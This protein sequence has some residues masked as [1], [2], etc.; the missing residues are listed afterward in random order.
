MPVTRIE[1]S[2]MW[3]PFA[4]V[5]ESDGNGGMVSGN[6]AEANNGEPWIHDRHMCLAENCMAWRENRDKR[7]FCGLA[8]QPLK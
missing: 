5:V 6:R 7:G 2:G 1:A 4:R 8:G 3:C